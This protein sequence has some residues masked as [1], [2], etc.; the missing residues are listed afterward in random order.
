MLD[1]NSSWVT[2]RS[3]SIFPRY[4]LAPKYSWS[5]SFEHVLCQT[6]N[7]GSF[8]N[9][10]VSNE[11]GASL[12]LSTKAF[13]KMFNLIL[14]TID[15]TQFPLQVHI[16][17]QYCLACVERTWEILQGKAENQ[18]RSNLSKS[19]LSMILIERIHSSW[20]AC[21]HESTVIDLHPR[22]C[23][24]SE[25]QKTVWLARDAATLEG[26]TI[27]SSHHL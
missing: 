16:A 23:H 8:A 17:I 21:L 10:H 2:F 11:A 1:F 13:S 6:L 12:C 18:V 27:F 5:C 9:S 4:L 3:T 19:I 14:A 7:N 24:Q 22:A 26:L 20:R 25:R 15:R